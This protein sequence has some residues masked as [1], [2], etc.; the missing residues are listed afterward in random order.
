MRGVAAFPKFYPA[1]AFGVSKRVLYVPCTL[2]RYL[3]GSV[4]G[5]TYVNPKISEKRFVGNDLAQQEVEKVAK[6]TRCGC[7]ITYIHSALALA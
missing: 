3:F 7:I 1:L 2:T 6:E 5:A 4:N